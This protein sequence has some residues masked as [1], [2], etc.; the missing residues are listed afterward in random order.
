MRSFLAAAL[1]ALVW[2]LPALSPA[3]TRDLAAQELN[4]GEVT[5]GELMIRQEE[6]QI[7]LDDR[8]PMTLQDRQFLGREYRY[9]LIAPSG[10]TLQARSS[11]RF[12]IGQRVRLS[13]GSSDGVIFSPE[14]SDP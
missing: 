14:R 7:E 8:G 11:L 4:Q 10:L 1:V 13:L 9:G 5:Q 6:L 3:G 12:S 2:A